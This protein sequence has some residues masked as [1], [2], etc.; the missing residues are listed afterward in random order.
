MFQKKNGFVKYHP[1]ADLNIN[2][3]Y[4]VPWNLNTFTFSLV[5]ECRILENIKNNF[6]KL[7]AMALKVTNPVKYSLMLGRQIGLNF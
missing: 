1:R 6:H 7:A 2:L 3:V 4:L 5:L